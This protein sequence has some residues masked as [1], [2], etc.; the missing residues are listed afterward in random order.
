[1]NVFFTH[2]CLQSKTLLQSKIGGQQFMELLHFA[3][4]QSN[5][6]PQ[7]WIPGLCSLFSPGPTEHKQGPHVLEAT[8]CSKKIKF[9]FF[10]EYW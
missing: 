1:M 7:A 3:P 9:N 2:T 6:H 5:V 8:N 4:F 10:V